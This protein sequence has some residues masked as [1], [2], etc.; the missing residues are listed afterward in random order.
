MNG[1]EDSGIIGENIEGFISCIEIGVS[2]VSV[3]P[4]ED[5]IEL[6]DCGDMTGKGDDVLKLQCVK[7]CFKTLPK[8]LF[9]CS[10]CKEFNMGKSLFR[11][12]HPA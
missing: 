9:D 6:I 12:Q 2:G 5:S 7:T 11:G 10:F 8:V 3:P 1:V 4:G